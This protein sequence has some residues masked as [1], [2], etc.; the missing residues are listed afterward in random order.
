[1]YRISTT[2][3]TRLVLN[4]RERS[5]ALAGLP[6]TVETMGKLQAAPPVAGTTNPWDITSVEVDESTSETLSSNLVGG[7]S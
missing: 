1:M 3:V 2:L 4:L 6:I 7:P 5:S